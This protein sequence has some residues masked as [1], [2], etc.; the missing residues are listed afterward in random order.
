MENQR[1]LLG[2]A[3]NTM[4]HEYQ[5]AQLDTKIYCDGKKRKSKA[6]SESP[7]VDRK[8]LAYTNTA[9]ADTNAS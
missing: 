2:L 9:K 4:N 3:G 6:K 1:R 8:L 7:G 5:I